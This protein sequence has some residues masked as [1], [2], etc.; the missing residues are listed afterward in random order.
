MSMVSV[1][2]SIK[3]VL[4]QH[5]M[6]GISC[7]KYNKAVT[8][9]PYQGISAAQ[10]ITRLPLIKDSSYG[11]YKK[12]TTSAPCQQAVA[13]RAVYSCTRAANNVCFSN[14]LAGLSNSFTNA[15][16]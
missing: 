11:K 6:N 10:C 2:E 5:H 16:R 8:S 3:Q 9:A 13:D 15:A 1:V 4:H 12:A 7:T 14:N